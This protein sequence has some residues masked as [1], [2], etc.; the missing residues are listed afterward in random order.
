[1]DGFSYVSYHQSVIHKPPPAFTDVQFCM[2]GEADLMFPPGSSDITPAI[3]TPLGIT[4]SPTSVIKNLA[5]P[6]V[7]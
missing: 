3:S 4:L 1:M 5:L 2:Y 6:I 7:T